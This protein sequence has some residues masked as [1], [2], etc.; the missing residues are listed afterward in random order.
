MRVHPRAQRECEPGGEPHIY[1]DYFDLSVV[2]RPKGLTMLALRNAAT[3]G[4]GHS[5]SHEGM[6]GDTCFRFV[7][8]PS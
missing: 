2:A 8:V 3:I 5:T 1:H 4:L 7:F 6:A